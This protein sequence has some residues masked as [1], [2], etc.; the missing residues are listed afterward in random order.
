M[1]LTA[2]IALW[3]R[4]A[5]AVRSAA[6]TAPRD[7][8]ADRQRIAARDGQAIG[9]AWKRRSPGSSYSARQAAHIGKP[10]M[11]VSGRS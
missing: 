5:M 11:V 3:R 1:P 7:L 8:R 6:S 10:A 9:W 2:T 4:Q